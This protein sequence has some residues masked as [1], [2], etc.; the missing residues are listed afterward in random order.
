MAQEIAHDV[1]KEAQSM[2]ALPSIDDSASPSAVAPAVIGHQ[3][4]TIHPPTTNETSSPREFHDSDDADRTSTPDLPTPSRDFAKS[5]LGEKALLAEASGGSDTD[6]SKPDG[7]ERKDSASGHARSNSVKKPATFKS[8]SVT[9][10]FLAKAAVGAVPSSRPG[11]KGKLKSFVLSCSFS[12]YQVVPSGPSSPIALSAAK[13]RLVAKSALGGLGARSG[14][15]GSGGPGA[16]PDASKVWN[17]NRRE[18]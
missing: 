16:G 4:V 8:V 7:L 12:N 9:K 14:L 11:D 13:P 17:R 5:P 6:T 1:V 15:T 3:I 10:N 2:G 18:K